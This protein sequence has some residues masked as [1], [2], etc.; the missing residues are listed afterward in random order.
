M[1][2]ALSH[3]ILILKWVIKCLSRPSILFSLTIQS[4]DIVFPE[5]GISD[6]V[7]H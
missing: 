6:M 1:R 2:R 5:L 7:A 3:C 4:L